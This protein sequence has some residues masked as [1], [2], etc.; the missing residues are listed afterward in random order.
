MKKKKCNHLV[1][2]FNFYGES[3]CVHLSCLFE[4]DLYDNYFELFEF[5]PYCGRKIK[6][7]LIKRGF[8]LNLKGDESYE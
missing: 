7:L 2:L 4:D 3:H 5:C 1:G 6:P 8:N